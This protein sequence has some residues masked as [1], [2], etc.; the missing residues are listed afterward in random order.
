MELNGKYCDLCIKMTTT[1]IYCHKYIICWGSSLIEMLVKREQE[2]IGEW[3]P[4]HT[5]SISLP[6]NIYME[7]FILSLQYLY[8]YYY[9]NE[10]RSIDTVRYKSNIIGLLSS[11]IYLSVNIEIIILLITELLPCKSLLDKNGADMLLFLFDAYNLKI[12]DPNSY[13]QVSPI[14]RLLFYYYIDIKNIYPEYSFELIDSYPF[15]GNENIDIIDKIS[16]NDT[17]RWIK[18][19]GPQNT[20][21]DDTFRNKDYKWIHMPSA[22][23]FL[24]EIRKKSHI[25]QAFGIK[26]KINRTYYGDA[27]DK[28]DYIS[29]YVDSWDNNIAPEISA[30]FTL[31]IYSESEEP[32]RLSTFVNKMILEDY[33]DNSLDFNINKYEHIENKRLRMSLLIQ[34]S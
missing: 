17:S 34:L 20:F 27:G 28:Y 30:K 22:Q 8:E 13:H 23:Y 2:K 14:F 6:D 18:F 10:H 31:I 1:N 11:L 5:L 7:D 33:K 29:I 21:I 24:P 15:F 26:W 32:I 4:V 9:H 3:P 19:Y 16:S 25:F 12:T